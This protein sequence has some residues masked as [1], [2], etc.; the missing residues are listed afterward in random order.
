MDPD[1]NDGVPWDSTKGYYLE[2]E[3]IPTTPKLYKH[4]HTDELVEAMWFVGVKQKLEAAF[5]WVERNTAGV[6]EPASYGYRLPKSGIRINYAS[7]APSVIL[8]NNGVEAVT[9]Y[10]D[11]IIRTV[12]D[13]FLPVEVNLFLDSYKEH[14]DN[15]Q[16]LQE[17]AGSS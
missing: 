6:Y 16:V 7:N 15:V 13:E 11:F 1:S 9:N 3:F 2:N 4:V 10:G 17:K 14:K 5:N 12:F 8:V